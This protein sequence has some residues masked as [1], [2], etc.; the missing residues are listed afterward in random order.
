MTHEVSVR[1]LEFV[2]GRI[3]KNREKCWREFVTERGREPA[4]EVA[5]PAS[6]NLL[7]LVFCSLFFLFVHLIL[8]HDEILN[9]IL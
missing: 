7:H 9:V 3:F 1:I 6:Q 8:F 2:H 4:P 5:S